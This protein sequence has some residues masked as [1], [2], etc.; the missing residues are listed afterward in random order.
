MKLF[1]RKVDATAEFPCPAPLLFEVLT[2]YDNYRDWFPHVSGSTLAAQAGEVAIALLDLAAPFE[3]QIAL[4]SVHTVNSSVL[5][6]VLNARIGVET[7]EWSLEGLGGGR[8]RVT[9]TIEGHTSLPMGSGQMGLLDAQRMLTVL[10][11]YTKVFGS[12]F[13]VDGGDGELLLEIIE[14]ENGLTC[15]WKGRQYEMKPLS[16]GLK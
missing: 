2:D 9:L 7:M 16:G 4:E 15:W 6:R 3:G 5:I 11:S 8:C 14:T 1:H 13:T 10:R 12:S